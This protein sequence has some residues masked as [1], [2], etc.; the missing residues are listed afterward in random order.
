MPTGNSEP[1]SMSVSRRHALAAALS[2]SLTLAALRRPCAAESKT[3]RMGFQ[4]GEAL[5]VAAKA[6]QV[7]ETALG[8]QGY[9][10]DWIEFPFGP[11]MLE[12]MRVGS[13]DLGAVG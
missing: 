11:P 7:L 1:A 5:L 9:A 13:I 3:L 4:K 12:A 2:A 10:V 8:P 6:H